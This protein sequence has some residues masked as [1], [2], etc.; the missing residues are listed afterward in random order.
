MG[1]GGKPAWCLQAPNGVDEYADVLRPHCGCIPAWSRALRVAPGEELQQ[2]AGAVKVAGNRVE[3]ERTQI[4]LT[5]T[6]FATRC[7]ASGPL[8]RGLF[9]QTVH[10]RTGETLRVTSVT[11][12]AHT[13]GPSYDL[14]TDTTTFDLEGVVSHDCRSFNL[15]RETRKPG[16]R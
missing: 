10:V 8:V 5:L 11:G 4:I 16:S 2:R 9:C 14:T 6:E 1:V 13:T 7:K 3:H 15:L 12:C